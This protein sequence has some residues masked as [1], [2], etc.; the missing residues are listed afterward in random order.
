MSNENNFN[1]IWKKIRL[2]KGEIFTTTRGLEFA[3]SILG[4]WVVISGSDFRITKSNFQLAFSMMPISEPEDFGNLIQ[5]K[6]FVHAILN[7]LRIKP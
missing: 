7:D 4:P 6:Y 2:H 1:E 5:G 3:Y